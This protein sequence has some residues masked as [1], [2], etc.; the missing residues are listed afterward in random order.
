MSLLATQRSFRAA[1]QGAAEGVAE[2]FD[3]PGMAAGLAIYHNAYRVQLV[4]C[5][6]ETFEQTDAWLGSP[7]FTDA[8]LIHIAENPPHGWTLG[9]YGDGLDA[10]LAR[11]YPDDPEVAELARLEWALSRAFTGA[12]ATALSPSNLPDISWDE[13]RLD[14]VPTLALYPA[15]TNVGAIWSALSSGGTPP[16]ATLLPAMT[17]LLI[18]RQDLTPS[19]RTIDEDEMAALNQMRDGMTF[20]ALCGQFVENLGE[21]EGVSRAGLLLG[22]WLH[23]GLVA[24]VR[25]PG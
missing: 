22:Q 19:F 23:D 21:A 13:A 17:W 2:H 10:T 15:K 5:L 20:G 14:F 11:L 9:I 12:N 6:R 3:D 8:A 24:T 7:A 4:D 1:L 25:A 18:W 16:A